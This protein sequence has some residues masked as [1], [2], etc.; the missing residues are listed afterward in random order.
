MHCH[1]LFLVGWTLTDENICRL[2]RYFFK[3]RPSW[4]RYFVTWDV[5]VLLEFLISWHP[6]SSLSLEKLTLKT[7]SLVAVTSSDRAQT[8]E[9]L[10]IEN[11]SFSS[12]AVR[13]PIFSQLKNS[14]KNHPV[15]VVSCFKSENPSLD[16]CEYVSSYMTRT[17]KFRLKAVKKGNPKPTQLFLSYF[18]G[19]PI[20][21]ATIAK[22]L[23]KTLELSG[24]DVTCYKAHT[25]RGALP[26]RL[27][28][29]GAS[30][31]TII[32]QGDWSQVST[33]NRFYNRIVDESPAGL[34][35]QEVMGRHNK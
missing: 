16:V 23:L 27:S 14:R 11:C 4:P 20:K 31:H 28:S 35:V 19:K 7:V 5:N 8:L 25:F 17:L 10:N 33:F 9:A 2:L 32:T 26:S 34:L 13:F 15:K 1:F 21:R 29:A 12:N 22:Y 3:A 30:A 6:S 18:T 24:I